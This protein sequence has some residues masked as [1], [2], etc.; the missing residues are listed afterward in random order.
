[1]WATLCV[2]FSSK[3]KAGNVFPKYMLKSK[4]RDKSI[5][6]RK[7]LYCQVTVMNYLCNILWKL[8]IKIESTWRSEIKEQAPKLIL[9]YFGRTVRI[10]HQ[11]CFIKEAVLK[12][13]A[14]STGNTCAGV[15]SGLKGCNF[16]K[17]KLQHRCF[18]MNIE[19]L[20][21]L[22]NSND[23]CDRMLLTVSMVHCYMGLKVQ[24]QRC[25]M[26]SGFWVWAAG[27]FFL[28]LSRHLSPLTEFR[29]AFE[30]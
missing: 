29:T 10:S 11:K 3:S 26:E 4:A 18:P 16:I 9:L 5:Q 19:K 30:T 6:T 7:K 25:M 22:P 12:N 8:L 28:S 24:S 20:L 2:S 13:L 1:M 14:I 27:L 15:S 21:M 17:K 23:I